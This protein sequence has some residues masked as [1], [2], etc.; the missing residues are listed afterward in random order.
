MEK[1]LQPKYQQLS[2]LRSSRL[3]QT[4]KDVFRRFFSHP[5]L[6]CSFSHNRELSK[7]CMPKTVSPSIS[8]LSALLAC[9]SFNI[10]ISPS[11]SAGNGTPFDLRVSTS[12]TAPIRTSH[13][14]GST[15]PN[16]GQRTL[17]AGN[18]LLNSYDSLANELCVP[19]EDV[20]DLGSDVF[21]AL[22]GSGF[23][24]GWQTWRSNRYH[25]LQG[26]V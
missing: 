21:K 2:A 19:L 1:V 15:P 16:F 7:P 6:R 24:P 3:Q 26:R 18:D 5:L 14:V 9:A 25:V 20:V 11:A 23:R 12:S 10:S 17:R 22:A 4:G 13:S 8:T